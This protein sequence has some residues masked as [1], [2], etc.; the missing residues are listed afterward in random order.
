MNDT[1]K[2]EIA[3]VLY[4]LNKKAKNRRD[5]QFDIALK[6]KS[7]KNTK[8]KR[9]NLNEELTNVTERKKDYY[10][11][12]TKI[13]TENFEPSCIHRQ[14]FDLNTYQYIS[15]IKGVDVEKLVNGRMNFKKFYLNFL[16]EKYQKKIKTININGMPTKTKCYQFNDI[17]VDEN[18]KD[19]I[20]DALKERFNDILVKGNKLYIPYFSNDDLDSVFIDILWDKTELS[21]QEND[22]VVYYDK[23]KI[24]KRPTV[25]SQ[26][27]RYYLLYRVD[28]Y[29]FHI[30]IEENEIEKH[31]H[32]KIYDV[33]LDTKG[34]DEDYLYTEKE[35]RNTLRIVS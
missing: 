10:A 13:L 2:K 34:I 26:N 21:A 35:I 6:Q 19:N 14:V 11:L 12:K 7:Y 4:S 32:L 33:T 18:I 31:N 24:I 17:I 5:E 16:D 20:L 27:V 22:R 28:K 29:S 30:P 15:N 3:E 8:T 23:L 25:I 1:N 9:N